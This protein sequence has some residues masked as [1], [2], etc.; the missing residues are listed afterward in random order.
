MLELAELEGKTVDEL[1]KLASS[2]K[3]T[4]AS[5]MNKRNL[6]MQIL[7]KQSE[8]DGHQ[9][10]YGILEI[11]NGDRGYLRGPSYEPDPIADVYIADTQIKRFNL[12]TGDMVGGPVRPP[13][14]SERF[15]SLLRVQSVNGMAP[16][17]ARNRPNFE[18]LTPVYP[19]QRLYLETEHPDNLSGR[20]LDL[21]TPLGR[22]QRGLIIA[23]PKAG[24]TTLIKQI[25][26]ALTANYDD[27]YLMVLLV[28]ERPEEV[29]DIAR[30]VDG[31]VVASTF[32]EMPRNHLRVADVVLERGKRLVEHGKDVVVLLDSITRLARAS[33]L[34]V[35][36]SGRTLSG[37]LDPTALYRPKRLF[38]AARNIEDG[39][40]LTIMATILVETGSRMDDMIYEEFKATGNLDLVLSRQ[41]ADKGTFPAVDITRSSTR[42]QELLFNDEEMQSVWQLRRALHALEAED[43][44]ELLISGIR[45]T[46][47][48]AE[49][50]ARAVDTFKK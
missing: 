7:A 32:D 20:F 30:S 10:R 12:R 36:P 19:N 46:R 5:S 38:G 28:D 26:N 50:L 48:N 6:C 37:G 1:R 47:N 11:V 17:Q 14:D 41:L 13:K 3:V 29:T 35:D 27:L 16:E 18:D 8:D 34:T 43:A 25:A 15:W 45:K 33:N 31:E 22:G 23:P 24:K 4:G 49:F 9:Y 21:I 40:S 44:A 2:L 39:G 42:H